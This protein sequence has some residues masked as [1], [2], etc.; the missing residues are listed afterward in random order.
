MVVIALCL[1]MVAPEGPSSEIYTFSPLANRF[2]AVMYPAETEPSPI[3]NSYQWGSRIPAPKNLEEVYQT[4]LRSY[5]RADAPPVRLQFGPDTIDSYWHVAKYSIEKAE[6]FLRHCRERELLQIVEAFSFDELAFASPMEKALFQRDVYQVFCVF[7]DLI[8]FDL[9]P[10][11]KTQVVRTLDELRI[12]FNRVLLSREE[13]AAIRAKLPKSI[14]KRWYQTQFDGKQ[15]TAYL[16]QRIL[17]EEPGWIELPFHDEAPKHFNDFQGRSFIRLFIRPPGMSSEEFFAFW[18]GLIEE[19]GEDLATTSNLPPLP[20]VTQTL[21][22]R[23]LG[24]FLD[25]GTYTD[26]G[27][28]EMVL[29]RIIK[30]ARPKLDLT[31]SDLKGTV[32]Y[33]YVMRRQKLMAQ[34]ASLGLVQDGIDNP[35]YLGFHHM[36]PDPRNAYADTVS[37]IRFN[38]VACH[39]EL[40]Y[41][42][43]TVFS[44]SR[45]RPKNGGNPHWRYNRMLLKTSEDGF[46]ILNT[47]QYN[48]LVSKP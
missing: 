37:T 6:A 28:P 20:P 47:P 7:H 35:S 22:L 34:P 4:T 12:L 27:F 39:S 44:I 1:W 5:S 38:C 16:P 8:N 41:G 48:Y 17:G 36:A 18:D 9:A 40:H 2:L 26:S 45:K 23:T 3:T 42:S 11:S 33:S 24:V 46:Y 14:D 31:T 43:S 25:D 15:E 13:L 32:V 21:L 19:Y 10:E 29:M 30:H